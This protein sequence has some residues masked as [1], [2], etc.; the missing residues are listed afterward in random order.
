VPVRM[1]IR[2]SGCGIRRLC[3]VG[4]MS[5]WKVFFFLLVLS[6]SVAPVFVSVAFAESDDDVALSA[7]DG[8]E[9]AGVDVSGLLVRLN[10]CGEL[11]VE[12]RV[13][14]GLGDFDEAV[15]FAGLCSEVGESVEGD[16]VDLRLGAQGSRVAELW[17]T[18]AG[19]LVGVVVVLFVGFFGWGVV[20]RRFVRRVLE[21]RVEVGEGDE[22]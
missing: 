10:D 14:Y 6:V 11:L 17:L 7:I 3:D 22:H 1:G 2:R 12:A 4:V 20:K 19:S 5:V 9:E 16:A 21:M 18:L 13:A 8:A 15:G